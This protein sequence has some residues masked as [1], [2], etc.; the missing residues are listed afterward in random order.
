MQHVKI[1]PSI[2]TAD[3]GHLA[4]QL[5][6]AEKGGADLI[7]LDVMDGWF[8][9][10]ISFGPLLIRSVRQYTSLPLDVHLM[11]QDPERYLAEFA[12]AGASILTVHVEA[13]V[14]LQRT[15]QQ[16][17]DLGCRVGLA[18]NPATPIESIREVVEMLDMVLVM[19]VNPGFGGQKFIPATYDKIRR[20]KALL[21]QQN[22]ACEVEVDGGV[23]V[24]NIADVVASGADVLVA[25][26]AVYNGKQSVG[27]NLSALRGALQKG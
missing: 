2:L 23:G 11:V 13:S 12:D 10:N 27:A 8:V 7:H 6:A 3:F 22:T 1:A 15:L 26:S 20:M 9:P 4:D 5:A 24:S 17:R 14:H 19:S 25:G 16:I 21:E 18:L